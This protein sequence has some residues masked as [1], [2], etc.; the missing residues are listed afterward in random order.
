MTTLRSMLVVEVNMC[1]KLQLLGPKKTALQYSCS[2]A[3][4]S[5]WLKLYI[6]RT[7]SPTKEYN[8]GDFSAY[9]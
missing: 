4:V 1:R 2:G 5:I 8:F 9:V 7:M 6:N 3:C